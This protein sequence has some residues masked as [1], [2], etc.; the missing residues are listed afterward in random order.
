MLNDADV[1]WRKYG[2]CRQRTCAALLGDMASNE[3]VAATDRSFARRNL[4]VRG[5]APVAQSIEVILGDGDACQRRRT[6]PA[7][8][9]PGKLPRFLALDFDPSLLRLINGD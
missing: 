3:A 7:A 6:E 5:E 8:E 1:L 9:A 2:F 4:M